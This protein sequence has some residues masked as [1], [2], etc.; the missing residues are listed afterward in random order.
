MQ[1]DDP[2]SAGLTHPALMQADLERSALLERLQL[3]QSLRLECL[4]LATELYESGDELPDI[5][6]V[7]AR[8]A[9]FVLEG[10]PNLPG[11]SE[12]NVIAMARR[13]GPRQRHKD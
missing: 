2:T 8:M 10:M 4:I 13:G 9:H 3:E 12:D 5:L 11:E 6:R 1:A 7:A